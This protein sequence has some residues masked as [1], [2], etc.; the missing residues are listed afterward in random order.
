MTARL[1]VHPTCVPPGHGQDLLHARLL[2]LGLTDLMIGPASPRGY[3][4]L[5]RRDAEPGWYTRM[6]SSRFFYAEPSGP[7]AA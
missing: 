2:D 4:E 3:R 5:V 7:V 1:F 6:D